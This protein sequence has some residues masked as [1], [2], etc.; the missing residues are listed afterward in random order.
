MAHFPNTKQCSRSDL[1]ETDVRS[2]SLFKITVNNVL[3]NA[4]ENVESTQDETGD[5]STD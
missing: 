4:V 3:K 5:F 2:L 1:N